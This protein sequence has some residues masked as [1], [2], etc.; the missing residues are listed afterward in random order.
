MPLC[1]GRKLHDGEQEVDEAEE[2]RAA[3]HTILYTRRELHTWR[4]LITSS[5]LHHQID[6]SKRQKR[7]S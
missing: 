3:A 1:M 6:A 5:G 7:T 4:M 2:V